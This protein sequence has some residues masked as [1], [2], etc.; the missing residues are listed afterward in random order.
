MEMKV[1]REKSLYGRSHPSIASTSG[2]ER[3]SQLPSFVVFQ[4]EL[5]KYLTILNIMTQI[6]MLNPSASNNS[7]RL[8]RSHLSPQPLHHNIVTLR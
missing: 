7:F 6:P 3:F 5:S 4:P 8:I 1:G 2:E